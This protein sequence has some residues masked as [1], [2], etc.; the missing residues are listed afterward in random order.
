MTKDSLT[1]NI[2]LA[3]QPFQLQHHLIGGLSAEKEMT[4]HS[5][6][7]DDYLLLNRALEGDA[8]AFDKLVEKH[9]LRL[10]AAA[11]RVTG[12]HEQ[13]ADAVSDALIRLYRTGNSF[14]FESKL[15]TWLHRV[16]VNCATDIAR[17]NSCRPTHSLDQLLEGYP[18]HELNS[19]TPNTHDYEW[20]ELVTY[21]HSR[22]VKELSVLPES[23]RDLLLAVHRDQT[24]YES[25]ASNFHVPI[26]TIKSRIF[27]ARRKLRDQLPSLEKMEEESMGLVFTGMAA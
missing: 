16:V 15:S 4:I 22:I 14:R 19:V 21:A 11:F 23:E 12:D 6:D 10:H 5:S 26:G 27:R 17:R 20:D 24:T 13:A 3:G 7:C 18:D 2:R 9:R 25:L 1:R 8:N